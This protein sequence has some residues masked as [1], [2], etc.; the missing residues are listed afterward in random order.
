MLDPYQRKYENKEEFQDHAG[1]Q[2]VTCGL[3]KNIDKWYRLNELGSRFFVLGENHAI[4]N[5]RSIME[6]SNQTGNALG[7]RGSMQIGAMSP[8]HQPNE[9]SLHEAVG[10]MTYFPMES[11]LS[12]TLF[13]LL[14]LADKYKPGKSQFTFAELGV[15]PRKLDDTQDRKTAGNAPFED[16]HYQ[17]Y[18]M[19]QSAL[20]QCFFCQKAIQEYVKLNVNSPFAHELV[21]LLFLLDKLLSKRIIRV[22]KALIKQCQLCADL[23]LESTGI[24]F[25]RPSYDDLSK[26]QKKQES[27]PLSYHANGNREA[28]MFQR[29]IEAA[30]NPS[31]RMAG[32][33]NEHAR[34]LKAPLE[35]VSIPVITLEEFLR[36]PY[37]LSAK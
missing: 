25:R 20:E 8:G 34:H 23:E 26:D 16:Y 12:K 10:P 19:R 14:Y 31:Y 36:P 33:G 37:T 21:Q 11:I 7:E 18:N 13:A 2:P 4:A 9:V 35:S 28:F 24:T 5:Y 1:G 6:E 29:I 27:D 22:K 3:I 17:P 30:S 32:M 15:Q